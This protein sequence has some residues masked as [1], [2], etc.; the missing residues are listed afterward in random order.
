MYNEAPAFRRFTL[1]PAA[2]Y[3]ISA[4]SGSST[5]SARLQPGSQLAP[6]PHLKI[7]I[8]PAPAQALRHQLRQPL[9]FFAL[10]RYVL[11]LGPVRCC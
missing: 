10:V 3:H 2:V 4:A 7:I 5:G 8:V 9:D 6:A 1:A 11:N